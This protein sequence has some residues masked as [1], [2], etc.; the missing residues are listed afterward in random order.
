MFNKSSKF[1]FVLIAIALVSPSLYAAQVRVDVG[2]GQIGRVILADPLSVSVSRVAMTAPAPDRA[3]ATSDITIGNI[4]SKATSFGDN[5]T[6]GVSA[7][8]SMKADFTIRPGFHGQRQTMQFVVDGFTDTFGVEL[9]LRSPAGGV[10]V[11]TVDGKIKFEAKNTGAP[12]GDL[13]S[14]EFDHDTQVFIDSASVAQA[15]HFHDAVLNQSSIINNS[16]MD[17]RITYLRLPTELGYRALVEFDFFADSSKTYSIDMS[18]FAKMTS[19]FA[20]GMT[21]DMSRSLDVGIRLG[22]GAS[23]SSVDGFLSN[24]SELDLVERLNISQVPIPGA[25]W[26]LL[27]ALGS[28]GLSFRRNASSRN[29]CVSMSVAQR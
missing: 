15:F 10:L 7:L 3:F 11:A 8:A 25:I 20:H 5:G 16:I 27:G 22:E 18:T 9:A 1:F 6:N 13:R 12:N 14:V 24:V 28:L 21:A 23:L 17:P 19:A 26:M 2:G 4:G 29:E